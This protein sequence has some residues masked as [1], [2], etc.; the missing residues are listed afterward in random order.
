MNILVDLGCLI[1]Y[2]VLILSEP[3]K[4]HFTLL[5]ITPFTV[6]ITTL[7]EYRCSLISGPD[8]FCNGKYIVAPTFKANIQRVFKGFL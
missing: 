6:T 4:T 7:T 3:N 8:L 1:M 5:S 2:E